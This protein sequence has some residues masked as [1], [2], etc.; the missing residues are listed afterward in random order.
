MFDHLDIGVSD[1]DA[2]RRFY[3]FAL[4]EPRDEGEWLEFGDFGIT[5]VD[6]DHP[7]T[8]RLHVGFGVESRE[9]VDAWRERLVGAGYAG[10]GEPGPRPEYTESY[11]GGFILD[12]DR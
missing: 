5:P 12:P 2:S 9:A 10:D 7:V 3:T 4:G 6:D 1:L 11:Y 8:R